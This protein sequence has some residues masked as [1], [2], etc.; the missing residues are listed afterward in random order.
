MD[1]G[2]FDAEALGVIKPRFLIVLVAAGAIVLAACHRNQSAPRAGTD[3]LGQ[4]VDLAQ[5]DTEFAKAS[6]DL[7]Q[8]AA[9]LK[10]AFRYSQFEQATA[11]LSYLA[12][13]TELTPGQKKL[14]EALSAQTAQALTNT[15]G[16]EASVPA[17]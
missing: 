9:V 14:V 4:P 5:L 3:F 10:H 8:H 16:T 17:K 7:Q 12:S 13:S 15:P 11:E 6:P 2:T 1:D